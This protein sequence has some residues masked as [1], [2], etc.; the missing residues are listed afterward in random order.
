MAQQ[1]LTASQ[2][3]TTFELF[4]SD[5]TELSSVEELA[6]LNR[7]YL[8]V[9]SDRPYE[10]LKTSVTGTVLN[11]AIGY[12]I[13]PPADFAYF[14]ENNQFTDNSIG[15]YN[16]AVPK[17]IF[18]ISGIAYSPYQIINF[19]DRR[20]Y[21]NMVGFAY[22]DTANNII[23]FT[24]TPV[25][26]SYEFDYI[27]IPALLALTDTPIFPG[28]FH[29]MLAFGMATDNDMLQLS[30]KASSYAQENNAKLASMKL[31]MD[32]WNSMLQNN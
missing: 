26:T 23:R 27:K 20:Q 17:V 8:K 15:V 30:P 16:N 31:D 3:I 9:C 28:R 25:T 1:S 21:V 5:V 13:T 6:L 22:Y 18:I 14:I 24:G 32:Y 10:F 19:S 11:D 29:E 2:I 12:Y 4:V 7:V